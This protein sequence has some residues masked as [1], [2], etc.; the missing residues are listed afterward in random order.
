MQIRGQCPFPGAALEAFYSE[1][2][3]RPNGV[4]GIQKHWKS[5][6][7]FNNPT[8]RALNVSP[9]IEDTILTAGSFAPNF[10]ARLPILLSSS[11]SLRC[12]PG[13]TS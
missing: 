10:S 1:R 13:E 3:P 4:R 7:L 2:R 6:Q 5:Q 11:S 9:Y 8:Q 12:S